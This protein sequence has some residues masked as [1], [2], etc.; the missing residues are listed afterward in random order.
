MLDR[1]MV[2]V[3]VLTVPVLILAPLLFLR[4]NLKKYL[5]YLLSLALTI[6][7]VYLLKYLF[8]V[9]RLPDGMID[10]TSPTFP[11]GHASISFVPV[12][13]FGDLK[14][15]LPFLGYSLLVSYSRVYLNVHTVID[16]LFGLL[17]GFI[18][19]LSLL[20]YEDKFYHNIE[21]VLTNI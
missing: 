5:F 14:L 3:S 2:M 11:S 8:N 9:P 17:V 13:F 10:K 20:M 21:K 12:V 4:K 16:V 18:V 1:F 7:F 6:G 15:R 19:P